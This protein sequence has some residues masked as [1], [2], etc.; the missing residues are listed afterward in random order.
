[1]YVTTIAWCKYAS[2]HSIALGNN[3]S[4]EVENVK[5]VMS[6]SQIMRGQVLIY[7]KMLCYSVIAVLKEILQYPQNV[8]INKIFTCVKS[9]ESFSKL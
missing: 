4:V 2:L 5:C 8:H 6:H 9:L 7:W 3:F 1:M